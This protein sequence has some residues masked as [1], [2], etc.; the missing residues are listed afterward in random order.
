MALESVAARS[1]V[2]ARCIS[3]ALLQR[4]QTVN[5]ILVACRALGE[6]R[7]QRLSAHVEACL[8][9]ES[10]PGTWATYTVGE[11]EWGVQYRARAEAWSRAKFFA[12]RRGVCSATPR[13]SCLGNFFEGDGL[14]EGQARGVVLAFSQAQKTET[15]R[16][17]V[18]TRVATQ[19]VEVPTH[20]LT[21]T[22][23]LS[24]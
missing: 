9:A 5:E 24:P 7:L 18:N 2:E 22:L 4:Q 21:L 1:S 17:T 11:D 10:V 20:T 23:T 8:R 6:A 16:R 3:V 12:W 13:R 19:E 14:S 15:R